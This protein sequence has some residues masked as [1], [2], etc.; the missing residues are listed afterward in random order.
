MKEKILISGGSGLIGSR[1]SEMLT[2]MNYEV[3]HLSR[4]SGAGKYKTIQWDVNNKKLDG[5]SLEGFKYIFNLAGAGIVDKPW[6]DERKLELLNS[7]VDSV[8]LLHEKIGQLQHKPEAFVSASAIGFYG[9]HTS[10]EI[11]TETDQAGN[12][13]LA[14]TCKKWEEAIHNFSSLDLSYSIVRIGLV[15]STKGG[16]LAEMAKPI[17]MGFGA[18]LGSGKQY[19]PWIHID[20]I[21]RLFIHCAQHKLSTTVNGVSQ[22]Q[23]NNKTF[24]KAVAKALGKKIWL[25]NVPTFMMR[26][27]LGSRAQIVLEGSRVSYD[28]H[29]QIDFELKYKNL[30]NSLAELYA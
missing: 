15:L 17:K 5:S 6:T 20:D 11:Y 21:C 14:D 16:A 25:P 18:A 9:I 30:E 12:D 24:T 7:R 4:Q 10:E 3:Y 22:N 27:I 13:F 1:M 19:M 2:E 29:A 23:V 8:M 28:K 26:L